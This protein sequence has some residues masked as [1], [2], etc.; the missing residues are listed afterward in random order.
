MA[1]IEIPVNKSPFNDSDAAKAFLQNLMMYNELITRQHGCDKCHALTRGG[2]EYPHLI[3]RHLAYDLIAFRCDVFS[4]AETQGWQ[5]AC[6][7]STI[8]EY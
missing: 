8:V 2:S 5:R 6:N 7:G 3:A 4:V 1:I